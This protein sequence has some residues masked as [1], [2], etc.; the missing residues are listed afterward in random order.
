MKYLLAVLFLAVILSACGV[1]APMGHSDGPDLLV[2][3]IGQTIPAV[4]D[5]GN[6]V[7]VDVFPGRV[8]VA[9]QALFFSAEGLP[10]D[11]FHVYPGA[12]VQ[13]GQVLASL[14]TPH[15]REQVA[16]QE[17]VVNRLRR[18]HA[19]NAEMWDID[20]EVLY[21]RYIAQVRRAAETLSDADMDEAQRL[22]LEMNRMRLLREQDLE[23]QR[24]ERADADARLI[25][26]RERLE[27]TDIIAPFDG[28]IT[29][30]TDLTHGG[31]VGPT[32]RVL[33]IAPA[34]APLYV[35]L[36]Q[37]FIPNRSRAYAVMGEINGQVV[38]LEYIPRSQEE[39]EY[40]SLHSFP[41][42][43]N[44]ALPAGYDFP[45]GASVRIFVYMVYLEDV[46]RFPASAMVGAGLAAYVYRREGGLWMPV[47][48]VLGAV[49]HTFVEVLEGLYEGDELLV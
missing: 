39:I 12:R 7:D 32:T 48:P 25:E 45:L 31:S 6:V 15:P 24:L 5:R 26:L 21:L 44:F 20:F 46:L 22:Y 3:L 10:F 27:G 49:T 35:E 1:A 30:I 9:S 37:E 8:A 43:T 33:F 29:Y 2:P 23:W 14:Y 17:I 19:L 13:A 34:D 41:R 18:N 40:E 16:N 36:I 28:V 42:R 11:A 4:V 38:P 47:H